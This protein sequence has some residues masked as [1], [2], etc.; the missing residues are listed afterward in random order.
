M[1]TSRDANCQFRT[2][3]T[4]GHVLKWARSCTSTGTQRARIHRVSMLHALGAN[5]PM[6]K[7]RCEGARGPRQL[8]DGKSHH[9][10]L[11]AGCGAQLRCTGPLPCQFK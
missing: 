6:R 3:A 11:I 10:H 5:H 4:T 9:T 8:L 1:R 2:P 7:G